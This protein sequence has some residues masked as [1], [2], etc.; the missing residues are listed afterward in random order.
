MHRGILHVEA[1][2]K[3]VKRVF[4]NWSKMIVFLHLLY[5]K[6][7]QRFHSKKYEIN[8]RVVLLTDLTLIKRVIFAPIGVPFC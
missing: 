1:W 8:L 5:M 2:S 4:V 3:N 6:A 7:K